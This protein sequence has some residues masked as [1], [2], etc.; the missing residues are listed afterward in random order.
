MQ[1]QQL[2]IRC[3]KQRSIIKTR[4]RVIVSAAV[5]VCLLRRMPARTWLVKL[6]QR[7]VR[8]L[9]EGLNSESKP[10][11][12]TADPDKI[13]QAFRRGHQ[14]LDSIQP[15]SQLNGSQ[16]SLATPLSLD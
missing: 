13:M 9:A 10:F 12:W 16:T 15:D 6:V 8:A 2:Q 1:I 4:Q 3:Q 11:T 7:L 5:V 14:V